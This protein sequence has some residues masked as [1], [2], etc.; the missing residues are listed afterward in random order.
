[1]LGP[2]VGLGPVDGH[3]VAK[4]AGQ[5]PPHLTLVHDL[6]LRADL[7][8]KYLTSENRAQKRYNVTETGVSSNKI[9][10]VF[11][12]KLWIRVH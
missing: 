7:Q 11:Q 9:P 4:I 5:R 1:V 3:D 12:S 6:L 8:K 2:G 10:T